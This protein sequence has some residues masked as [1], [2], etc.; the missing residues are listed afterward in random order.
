MAI[1][2]EGGALPLPSGYKEHMH[3]KD[4]VAFTIK[5]NKEIKQQ[6]KE[7]SFKSASHVADCVVDDH[8]KYSKRG[9]VSTV[10]GFGPGTA[11]KIKCYIC[12]EHDSEMVSGSGRNDGAFY[13]KEHKSMRGLSQ[14]DQEF[15]RSKYV[16]K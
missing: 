14:T 4:A 10:G 6:R 15:E 5:K 13:C 11:R 7:S 1:D 16:N 2:P 3:I 8:F 12:Q 9:S